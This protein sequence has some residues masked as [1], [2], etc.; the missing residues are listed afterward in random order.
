MAGFCD[1]HFKEG[2]TKKECKDFI[3]S[4]ISLAMYNDSSSG[5]IIRLVD[6]TKDEVKREYISHENLPIK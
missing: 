2:M 3:V 4:A 1:T 6:I 5:G